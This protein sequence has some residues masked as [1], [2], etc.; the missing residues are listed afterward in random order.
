MSK[1]KKGKAATLSGV[2]SEMVKVAGK[3]G[4]NMIIDLVNQMLIEKVIPAK[5]KLSPRKRKL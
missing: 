4:V 1:K 5:L 2:M 3:T